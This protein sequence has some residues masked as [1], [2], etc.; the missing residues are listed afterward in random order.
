[1]CYIDSS[2]SKTYAV[3]FV[4]SL[5][6][7]FEIRLRVFNHVLKHCKLKSGTHLKDV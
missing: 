3:K 5:T 1:M 6:L 4:I 2:V 7:P